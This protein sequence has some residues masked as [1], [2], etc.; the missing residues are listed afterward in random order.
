MPSAGHDITGMATSKRLAYLAHIA[1]HGRRPHDA[2]SR[3]RYISIYKYFF[4]DGMVEP[5]VS[6][7]GNLWQLLF[8]C[9][10][11]P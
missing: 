2:T 6:M 9:F 10:H 4:T 7:P 5:S 1:Y 11:W 8:Y 3:F